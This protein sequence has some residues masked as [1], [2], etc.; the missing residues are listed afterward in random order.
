MGETLRTAFDLL[1]GLPAPVHWLLI[2][3]TFGFAGWMM[4]REFLENRSRRCVCCSQHID[5]KSEDRTALLHC[6]SCD[7]TGLVH[8]ACMVD[9]S[10]VEA[11]GLR[12]ESLLIGSAWEPPEGANRLCDAQCPKCRKVG[13][14]YQ[15]LSRPLMSRPFKDT[16]VVS[17]GVTEAMRDQEARARSQLDADNEALVDEIMLLITD[18][19]RLHKPRGSSPDRDKER[20]YYER[21]RA[22]GEQ[23]FEKGGMK[24]THLIWYR[25]KFKSGGDQPGT[26]LNTAWKGIGNWRE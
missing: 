3:A 23:L 10:S 5:L 24:E 25:V 22:I 17:I 21:L 13:M 11:L 26:M 2:V 4:V 1:A 8:L 18:I 9:E 16:H 15:L 7:V 19:R 14:L 20:Y 12:R 6:A